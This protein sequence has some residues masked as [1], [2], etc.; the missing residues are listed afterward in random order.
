MVTLPE[1]RFFIDT[2]QFLT[3]AVWIKETQTPERLYIPKC[4]TLIG[5]S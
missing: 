5:N 1:P 3:G 2:C 4:Y